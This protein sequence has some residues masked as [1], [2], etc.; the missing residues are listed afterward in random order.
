NAR[1]ESLATGIR[2]ALRDR[3]LPG[4]VNATGS[5]MTFFFAA[6][7][8]RNYDGAKRSDT[9][10]FAAF[11]REMLARGVLLP[12]SQFEAIFVSA[13]HS[14]EDIRRTLSAARESLTA[15]SSRC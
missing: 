3:G 2:E 12:P 14:D 8:V 1:A 7:P 13:A 11:F 10:R 9:T 5:L 4:Q 6:D 15:I